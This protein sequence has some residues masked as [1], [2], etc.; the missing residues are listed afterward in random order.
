[1]PPAGVLSELMVSGL[2]GGGLRL[3]ARGDVP[4]AHSLA[5][6][7]PGGKPEEIYEVTPLTKCWHLIRPVRVPL[8]N[9]A[10]WLRI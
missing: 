10:K 7:H 6:I 5:H 8:T 9:S 4:S 3:P 2:A 1:M